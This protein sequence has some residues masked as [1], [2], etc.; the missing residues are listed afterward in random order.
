MVSQPRDTS[1]T[2]VSEDAA[3][4]LFLTYGHD[5]VHMAAL[6]PLRSAQAVAVPP[7][8]DRRAAVTP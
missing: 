2:D 6:S 3:R 5:A 1:G 7:G 8:Q 4:V